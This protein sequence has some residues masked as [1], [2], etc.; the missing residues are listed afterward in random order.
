[1]LHDF[2]SNLSL[3]KNF[4]Q[5]VVL[6]PS[7]WHSFSPNPPLQWQSVRFGAA[8][9]NNVPEQRGIY[10]FVVQFQDHSIVPIALP[11]HGYVM[12]GGIAGH[13]GASR[14]LRDRFRDYLR[15]QRRAKRVQIWS[16]LNKWRDDLFF[17]FSVVS[18]T[19]DL[20]TMEYA[21]NDAIIPPYVTN[22]FS[23]EVRP[24]VRALRAN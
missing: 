10:A 7:R 8:T 13:V 14:T 18:D 6:S 9:I 23:A 2:E 11:S 21:L 24:L 19:T 22:D 15:D 5:H 4:Q 3:L 17:H 1:M 20:G 16:M 12:Y